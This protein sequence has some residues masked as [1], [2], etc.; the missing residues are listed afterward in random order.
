V[1]VVIDKGASQ[2]ALD[3]LSLPDHGLPN[4]AVSRLADM[5]PRECGRTR[6]AD[7]RHRYP[8]RGNLAR[9]RSRTRYWRRLGAARAG[10]PGIG[11]PRPGHVSIDAVSPDSRRSDGSVSFSTVALDPRLHEIPSFT[12]RLLSVSD[13]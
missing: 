12:T 3:R 7:N 6:T 4:E 2:H 8:P 9:N 11:N 10:E 1:C 5:M 13:R